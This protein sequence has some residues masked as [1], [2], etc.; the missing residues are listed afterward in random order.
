M[1]P[2]LPGGPGGPVKPGGR[3]RAIA[4]AGGLIGV[5]VVVGIIVASLSGGNKP[6][7]PAASSPPPTS[8]PASSTPATSPTTIHPSGTEALTTIMNPAEAG[9]KPLGTDCSTAKLFGLQA[10]TLDARTFCLHTTHAHIKVWGYQF[11]SLADYQAGLAHIN[12]YVGFDQHTPVTSCPPSSGSAEGKVG[13]HAIHNPKY[14]SRSGQD[15]ECL[16]DGGNP[17]VIWTMP[18]QDVFFIGQNGVKGTSI[19]TV[20]SWWKTLTYG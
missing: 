12:H 2:L 1:G 4:I 17:V 9:A 14:F 11:D 6:H 20:I 8:A 3:G 10:S 15:L 19:S 7:Q 18:T 13:W 16:V 5:L